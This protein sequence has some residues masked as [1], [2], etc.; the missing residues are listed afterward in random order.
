[1]ANRVPQPTR[2]APPLAP[3]TFRTK[4]VDTESGSLCAPPAALRAAEM[5]REVRMPPLGASPKD[6]LCVCVWNHQLRDRDRIGSDESKPR[7]G[8][9][10]H[11]RTGC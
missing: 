3:P 11:A 6:Q 10:T 1:M 2:T 8:T 5:A 7:A 9:R 4:C